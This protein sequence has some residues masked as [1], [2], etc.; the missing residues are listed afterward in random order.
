MA[1]ARLPPLQQGAASGFQGRPSAGPVAADWARAYREQQHKA[2]QVR[3]IPAHRTISPDMIL[4][5]VCSQLPISVMRLSNVNAFV[6]C[7]R[8]HHYRKP[9]DVYSNFTAAKQ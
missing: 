4:D 3:H 8:G 7:G 1:G 6:E 9:H 5:M 2:A